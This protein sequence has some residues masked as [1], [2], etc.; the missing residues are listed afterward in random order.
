ML[1]SI[2]FTLSRRKKSI[3]FFINKK[4]YYLFK[5]LIRQSI[6]NIL[7]KNH[8]FQLVPLQ[9]TSI[10]NAYNCRLKPTR[11]CLNLGLF[12]KEVLVF[13]KYNYLNRKKFNES[14][15]I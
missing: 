7:M 5:Y 4:K 1:S 12:V 11:I 9:S 13:I 15:N 10:D 2:C 3:N 14:L 6:S 8:P